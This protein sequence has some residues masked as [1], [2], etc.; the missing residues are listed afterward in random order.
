M[1]LNYS[2][3][4]WRQ[5]AQKSLLFGLSCQIALSQNCHFEYTV[6][7]YFLV[8]YLKSPVKPLSH[9]VYKCKAGLSYFVRP[10][11]LF[12]PHQVT[13]AGQKKQIKFKAS[14]WL[15][16][17]QLVLYS[18]DLLLAPLNCYGLSSIQENKIPVKRV[19]ILSIFKDKQS[20]PPG[21]GSSWKRRRRTGK[22]G[23]YLR[24]DTE[25]RGV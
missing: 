11:G 22:P 3:R 18:L 21:L 19:D 10:T 23:N 6:Q 12:Q 1:W 16:F 24:W 14:G 8:V 4:D 13:T 25:F 2:C 20:W 9:P 7:T 15:T 17:W 5:E